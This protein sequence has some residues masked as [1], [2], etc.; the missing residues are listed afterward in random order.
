M[1]HASEGGLMRSHRAVA[2]FIPA[3]LAA[4]YFL[5][6]ARL[7][8]GQVGDSGQISSLLAE[9]QKEAVELKLDSADLEQFTYSNVT[10]GSYSHTIM[11]IREHVNKTGE[12]LA[13]LRQVETSGSPW[14]QTAIKQIEPLLGE[15]A[16]NTT[17]TIEHLNENKMNVHFPEFKEYARAN[18][19]LAKNLEALIHDFVDYAEAKEE[20]ERMQHKVGPTD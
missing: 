1:D 2:A 3:L 10:Y 13:R 20:V 4:G 6:P 12:L 15:L 18:Y 5:T 16:A 14:Q 9:A 19:M 7:M 17:R 11:L 8:S